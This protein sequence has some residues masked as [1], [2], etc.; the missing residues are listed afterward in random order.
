V[1]SLHAAGWRQGSFIERDL[2]ADVIVLNE[3]GEV[4]SDAFQHNP[5]LM[6]SHDCDLA[7]T[8][9]EAALP[10]MELRPVYTAQ[11]P[12]VLGLRSK[13]L[14][15]QPNAAWYLEAQSPRAMIQPAVLTALIAANP[16]LRTNPL[17]AEAVLKLKIWLGRRY[18]RAA[19]PDDLVPLAKAICDA[20]AA[21]RD[22]PLLGR[23]REVFW[24][25]Q[26][27][28]PNRFS[29]FAL[30]EHEDDRIASEELLA[31][32]ALD[33]PAELGTGD[34]F[35]AATARTFSLELFERSLTADLSDLTWGQGRSSGA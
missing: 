11:P 26:R 34:E 7:Q 1:P 8:P 35:R 18:D 10:L 17:D 29:L 2:S 19:V 16:N 22:D 33:V 9:S 15:L 21:R 12:L 27:G 31:T 28:N 32:A 20:I 14:R 13:K 5:W 3:A 25:Y 4:S 23:I 6:A 30:I 24:Q